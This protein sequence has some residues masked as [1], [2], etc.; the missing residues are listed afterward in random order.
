[1]DFPEPTQEPEWKDF[2]R[3]QYARSFGYY[4]DPND[5]A[6]ATTEETTTTAPE[7]TPPA[8]PPA[9]KKETKKKKDSA[10]LAP[11]ASRRRPR[12]PLQRRLH[13]ARGRAA[14]ADRIDRTPSRAALLVA[15]A[16]ALLVA[17]CV[18]CAWIERAPI[19]PADA[20][21]A[22]GGRLGVVFLALLV[23]AF[24]V[25]SRARSLLAPA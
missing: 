24:A 22:D 3:G 14:V 4:S 21:R 20:G 9:A 17:G 13:D 15:G 5:V 19:V 25:L 7:E 10:P 1:M 2:E 8:E 12:R 23:A 11:P 18:A 16:V 6:P